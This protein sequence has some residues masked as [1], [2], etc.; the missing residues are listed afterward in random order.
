MELPALSRT[1][2][3]IEVTTCPPMALCLGYAVWA[4][5][6]TSVAGSAKVI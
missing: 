3:G 2:Y 4:W 1:H 6:W 5:A